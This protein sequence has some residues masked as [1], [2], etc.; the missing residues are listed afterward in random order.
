MVAHVVCGKKKI[1]N[2]HVSHMD[3]FNQ[4]EKIEAPQIEV[5]DR[6]S[7]LHHHIFAVAGPT[8]GK[9]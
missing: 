7:S 6:T 3:V 4:R 1:I 9:S 8:L 5:R 2:A